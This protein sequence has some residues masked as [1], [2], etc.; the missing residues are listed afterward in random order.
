[1]DHYKSIVS[2]VRAQASGMTPN[3]SSADRAL[4]ASTARRQHCSAP[5]MCRQ[6]DQYL[7]DWIETID[8]THRHRSSTLGLGHGPLASTCSFLVDI[9]FVISLAEITG[10]RSGVLIPECR[11]YS[12]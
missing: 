1:M 5:A 10:V 9:A 2:K 12:P 6:A 8:A 11:R 4:A 7:A 3:A